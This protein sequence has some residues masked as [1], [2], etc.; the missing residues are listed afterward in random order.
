[1]VL[2]C[3]IRGAGGNAGCDGVADDRADCG[4]HCWL[5]GRFECALTCGWKDCRGC[6]V[7]DDSCRGLGTGVREKGG[8][9]LGRMTDC[10]CGS[11]CGGIGWNAFGFRG[12]GVA[13]VRLGHANGG[14]SVEGGWACDGCRVYGRNCCCC[15]LR[16]G[17]GPWCVG[18]MKRG[19]TAEGSGD[20]SRSGGHGDRKKV[21]SERL[22]LGSAKSPIA[23]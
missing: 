15:V 19:N 21:D 7:D 9:T 17:G 2:P 18:A 11:D 20:V 16:R 10:C 8:G 3:G 5:G 13:V 1:M 14:F 4:C 23:K 12:Y 22:S 6:G